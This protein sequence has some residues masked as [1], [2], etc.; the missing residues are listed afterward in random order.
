VALGSHMAYQ[1][2]ELGERAL[3]AWCETFC[4]TTCS[5]LKYAILYYDVM[6]V[7]TS[8]CLSTS[9]IFSTL[10]IDCFVLIYV[11]TYM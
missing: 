5:T 7:S 3:E 9:Y 11:H 2:T 8:K 6:E 1:L 4:K 10:V